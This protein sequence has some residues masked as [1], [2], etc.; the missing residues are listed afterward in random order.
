LLYKVYMG[1]TRIPLPHRG[2]VNTA[3]TTRTN[4]LRLADPT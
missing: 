4:R 3:G 1:Q 2:F